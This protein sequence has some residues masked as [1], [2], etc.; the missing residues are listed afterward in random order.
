MLRLGLDAGG[1]YTDAVLWDGRRVLHGT[2]SLTTR[3]DPIGGLR[4]SLHKLFQDFDGDPRTIDFVGLS[5]TLATNAVVEGFGA[6][7]AL[8]LIGLP[9]YQLP[10]PPEVNG[11]EILHIININGGH[12]AHGDELCP[13]DLEELAKALIDLDVSAYSVCAQFAVRNNS[14][15][16]QVRDYLGTI[17]DKPVTCSHQ[18]SH[19]LDASIRAA[20][21]VFNARLIPLIDRLINAVTQILQEHHIKA[22]V[23]LVRADGGVMPARIATSR[24]IETLLSGPAASAIGAATLT[25]HSDSKTDRSIKAVPVKLIGL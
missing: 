21:C 25:K 2:K 3:P 18:L 23:Y 10:K 8:I 13:L 5:S 12:D 24:P 6:R 7:T 16:I 4:A 19:A 14:H 17:T 22:P 1:T 20:T 15:E 11:N 9:P